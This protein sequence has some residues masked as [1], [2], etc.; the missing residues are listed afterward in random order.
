MSLRERLREGFARLPPGLRREVLHGLGRY[1]PWEV[2]FDFTPPPLGPGEEAGPPSFVGIGAQKAGTTWWYDLML[3]H[4]GIS[5][6]QEIHKE[7]HFFDRFGAQSMGPSDIERYHGWF[8]R[9]TGTMTG[10]WT[11]DYL[12]FPWVPPLLR[13]AAPDT[14]L[15][16]LVRDPVERFRSGLDHLERM[17][18]PRDG[19]AIADAVQRGFY[20]RALEVWLDHFAVGQLLVLQYER[21]VADR[22]GQL[23]ATFRH[24]G[25]PVHHLPEADRPARAPADRRQVLDDDV[26]R[27][28]I[29]LYA[30]DVAALAAGHAALDLT[31]WPNFAYL[32]GS[33]GSGPGPNSPSRRP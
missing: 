20:F 7:R 22:A 26:R 33:T 16:L 30:P 11:P 14:R 15:L 17:G 23:D 5:S 3:T 28:L 13:Q 24:L 25:L 4:P 19:T 10:E 32:T 2:G 18:T 8:P 9:A 27:R 1:A 21:C 6:R 31:L 29:S 12:T